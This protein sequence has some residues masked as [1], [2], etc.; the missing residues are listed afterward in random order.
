MPA[1]GF[2]L[3]SQLP[4][5]G[6]RWLCRWKALSAGLPAAHVVPANVLATRWA[7]PKQHL[8]F[9]GGVILDAHWEL[10]AA[11]WPR[12]SAGRA[13]RP[14]CRRGSQHAARVLSP[15][16]SLL[17]SPSPGSGSSVQQPS[18]SAVW[19]CPWSSRQGTKDG[20]G[21]APRHRTCTGTCLSPAKGLSWGSAD[22]F[23]W[24]QSCRNTD[25]FSAGGAGS[26]SLMSPR[27][28]PGAGGMQ[29]QGWSRRQSRDLRAPSWQSRAQPPACWGEWELLHT[30]MPWLSPAR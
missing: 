21:V 17:L 26:P 13:P 4:H 14:C 16:R 9:L 15:H 10:S 1:G 25:A 5:S 29:L 30:S 20:C 23:P 11:P 28:P 22:P 19:P 3:C 24:T 18:R 27:I 7:E 6:A 8:P 2:G 12:A